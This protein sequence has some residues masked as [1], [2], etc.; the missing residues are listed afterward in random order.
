[1]KPL[2]STFFGTASSLIQ[3]W[4]R[5]IKR[6]VILKRMSKRLHSAV[7]QKMSSEKIKAEQILQE[8]I[9]ISTSRNACMSATI[10]E[11]K[12]S[13]EI[14]R[15]VRIKNIF[16]RIKNKIVTCSFRT[17]SVMTWE[18]RNARIVMRMLLERRKLWQEKMMRR[19]FHM[20]ERDLLEKRKKETSLRNMSLQLKGEK[21]LLILTKS[22]DILNASE[23]KN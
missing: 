7:Q 18:R 23:K 1:M 4:Y 13:Q 3:Q 8:H 11:K 15:K 2:F 10:K 5:N 6:R 9:M 16:L 21:K 22:N 12:E 14:K 20:W 19:A 17:W